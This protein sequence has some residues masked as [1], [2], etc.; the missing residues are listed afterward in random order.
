MERQGQCSG[1]KHY[2]KQYYLLLFASSSTMEVKIQL[3]ALVTA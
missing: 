2:K 1:K 3:A